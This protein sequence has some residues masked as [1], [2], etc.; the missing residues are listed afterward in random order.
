MIIEY[1]FEAFLHSIAPQYSLQNLNKAADAMIK[2]DKKMHKMNTKIEFY[3]NN[4]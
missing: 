3:Q 4:S 1:V 2:Q